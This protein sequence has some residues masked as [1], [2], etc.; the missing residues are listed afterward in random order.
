MK[1]MIHAR[2]GVG[3]ALQLVQEGGRPLKRVLV[4][5]PSLI[6][7]RFG[8]KRIRAGTQVITASAGEMMAVA[9][10]QEVEVANLRPERGPY[11]AWC[12]AFDPQLWS[13]GADPAPAAR[14]IGQALTVGRPPKYLLAA[15][16]SAMRA[17]DERRGPPLP[18]A[19]H[20][21]RE[22][23]MGLGLL[24]GRFDVRQLGSVSGR[25]RRQVR[26]DLAR[27]WKSGEVARSLGMSEPTLRRRLEREGT[28][29]RRLLRQVRMT[30]ALTLLQSSELSVMQVADA[31]GYESVS[32]FTT[33]FRQY[34]GQSPGHLRD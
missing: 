1:R 25:V 10:G 18:I 8:R 14:R 4:E 27:R 21:L 9:G 34:F 33:R 31:V 6:L 24:G 26:A 29:F 16:R 15:F 2:E 23:L 19:R 32:Q 7:V 3:A 28:T 13:E 22:V 11:R 5:W 17:C 12:L 20:Q 30:S